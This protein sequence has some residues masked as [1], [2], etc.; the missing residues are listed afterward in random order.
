MHRFK[1][2]LPALIYVDGTTCLMLVVQGRDT[3]GVEADY[4]VA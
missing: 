4:P 3:A 1:F 2:R